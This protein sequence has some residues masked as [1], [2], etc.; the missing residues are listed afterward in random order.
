MLDIKFRNV[1]IEDAVHACAVV[2]DFMSDY[3]DRR[4]VGHGVGY[5][6]GVSTG[7]SFRFYVYRTDKTVV[8]VGQYEG[9]AQ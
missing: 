4:G 7:E 1:K 5:Q 9:D 8:C 2:S 3:A 6:H